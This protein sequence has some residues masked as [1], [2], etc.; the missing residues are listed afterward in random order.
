MKK[1]VLIIGIFLI[2]CCTFILGTVISK[3]DK[4]KDDTTT[5]E[6]N[7]K[8][9][10]QTGKIGEELFAKFFT[11]EDGLDLFNPKEIENAKIAIVVKT[12]AP[13][14]ALVFEEDDEGFEL[15]MNDV[16]KLY[17]EMFNEEFK[18]TEGEIGARGALTE[19]ALGCE[20]ESD[21]LSC[22][23]YLEADGATAYRNPPKYLF[24]EE[25]DDQVLLYVSVKYDLTYKVVFT[26]N[27]DNYYFT[28]Y[29][30]A[31]I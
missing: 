11:Y 28:S 20:V 13:N 21:L 6:D 26:K 22:G 1:V 3:N 16:K 29:E 30:E 12:L 7:G 4:C 17:K 25:K 9:E 10:L 18:I 31:S 27:G 5:K 24:Y 19:Y 8:V 14:I 23:Y 2:A 15:K